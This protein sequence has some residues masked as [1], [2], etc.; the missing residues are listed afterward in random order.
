MTFEYCTLWS[1]YC[2]FWFL[3]LM[4]F[5]SKLFQLIGTDYTHFS[6]SV[7]SADLHPSPL[8]Q[9][10]NSILLIIFHVACKLSQH[11]GVS[12]KLQFLLSNFN[13]V[14]KSSKHWPSFCTR[15]KLLCLSRVLFILRVLPLENW[16]HFFIIT[17]GSFFSRSAKFNAL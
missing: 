6:S 14:R 7:L 15:L 5:F 11:S 16:L 8:D 9:F 12:R 10:L 2:S 4:K 1:N 17:V 3:L 13:S